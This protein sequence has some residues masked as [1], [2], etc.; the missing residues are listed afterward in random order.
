MYGIAEGH[1]WKLPR[2]RVERK[3]LRLGKRKMYRENK[4]T[5]KM[6]WIRREKTG[7]ERSNIFDKTVTNI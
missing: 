6:N 3:G 4:K 1:G 2:A 5:G 7:K